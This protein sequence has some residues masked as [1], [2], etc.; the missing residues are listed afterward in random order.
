MS[1]IKQ[2]VQ[3]NDLEDMHDL[4]ISILDKQS[5]MRDSYIEFVNRLKKSNTTVLERINN[6]I[7]NESNDSETS[8]IALSLRIFHYKIEL[9]KKFTKKQLAFVKQCLEFYDFDIEIKGEIYLSNGS[10]IMIGNTD[11][12]FKEDRYAY[13]TGF[14]PVPD[15]L[16]NIN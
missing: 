3:I 4:H 1:R 7:K 5:N 12:R 2:I 15:N 8:I 13:Y 16:L 9:K 11:P 14:T 10:L 6:L